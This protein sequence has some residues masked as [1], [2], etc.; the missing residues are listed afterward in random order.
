MFLVFGDVAIFYIALGFALAVRRPHS[1][2]ENY[3]LFHVSYFTV[4][5]PVFL[6]VNII[7][8]LYDF[9]NIRDLPAIIGESLLAFVYSFAVSLGVFYAFARF[10]PSPKTHLALTLLFAMLLGIGWRRLW[11][12]MSASGLFATKTLLLD[13]SP[14]KNSIINDLRQHKYTRF[15]LVSPEVF[16]RWRGKVSNRRPGEGHRAKGLSEIIDL[17][18][19]TAEPALSDPQNREII[20]DAVDN[21]VPIWTYM[22]FY[23]EIYKKIPLYAVR[24]PV[25]LLTHVLHRRNAFYA[26]FKRVFDALAAGLFMLV[27]SPF[28]PL[29]ALAIKLTDGGP[30]FYSQARAG[31][32]KESFNMWK[33]RTMSPGADKLGYMWDTA[34]AD[35]R[36]TAVGRFLRKFRI[37]ELP[38]LWNIIRGEMSLVGPRPTW[39]GE[40]Q[41]RDIPD[42]HIRR[43]VKPGLTGWA[44]IN[45]SATDSAEDTLEKLGY[46]LYYIKNI[47]FALDISILLKTARR[48]LQSDHALRRKHRQA[49]PLKTP[50]PQPVG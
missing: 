6:G 9:R 26:L 10:L 23:E 27:L 43:L 7:L 31:H 19:V 38:Q 20:S 33:F 15:H 21:G 41:V 30:V 13:D 40:K 48:V 44:Q 37:D 49:R 42:Y 1:F 4:I 14:V 18:V 12:A 2:S 5:L 3:Y 46:D 25:W 34:G 8:G 36:V 39:V 50:E 22:D 24:N 35:P 29:I 32:L 45:S 17:V 11:M 28:L 16:E 47:S